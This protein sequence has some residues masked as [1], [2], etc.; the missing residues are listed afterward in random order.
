VA[1]NRNGGLPAGTVYNGLVSDLAVNDYLVGR[2][3]EGRGDGRDD[4][5]Q[6]VR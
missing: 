3:S 6:P 5:R 1:A 2:E 4:E